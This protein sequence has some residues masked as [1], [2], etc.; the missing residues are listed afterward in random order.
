MVKGH[1]KYKLP[2]VIA[3]GHTYSGYNMGAAENALINILTTIYSCQQSLLLVIDEIELGLHEEAQIRLVREL[4]ELCFERHLQIICTTHSPVIL[5]ALPPEGRFY[6][7]RVSGD[8]TV[9][10]EYLLNLHSGKLSGNYNAELDLFVE[11]E[12]ARTIV[13]ATLD[14]E[15]ERA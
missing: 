8:T 14:R 1:S 12:M 10:T 11:D 4:N 2:M 9:S 7:E 5:E 6:L 13:N 3:D 15:Q